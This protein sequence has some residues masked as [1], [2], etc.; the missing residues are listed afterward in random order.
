MLVGTAQ[1]GARIVVTYGLQ[2]TSGGATYCVT[3]AN[4]FG[5]FSCPFSGPT[6]M[7]VGHT[8][9]IRARQV[10]YFTYGSAGT[11]DLFYLASSTRRRFRRSRRPRIGLR[12]RTQ[13]SP[14]RA[15]PTAR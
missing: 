2:E 15:I 6:P 1:P 3:V 5:G 11:T 8:Y 4:G 10:G 9:F 13:P 14:E 12:R 7:T